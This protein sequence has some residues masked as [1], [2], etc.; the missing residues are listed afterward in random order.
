[1][2]LNDHLS[3]SQNELVRHALSSSSGNRKEKYTAFN[4]GSTPDKQISSN[5]PTCSNARQFKHNQHRPTPVDHRRLTS[6]IDVDQCQLFQGGHRQRVEQD[7]QILECHVKKEQIAKSSAVRLVSKSVPTKID[8]G[9]KAINERND[10]S[11]DQPEKGKRCE[12]KNGCM[13]RINLEENNL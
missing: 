1:M 13:N 11:A 9:E 7:D 8:T 4:D 10:R 3:P 2:L 6:S 5:R 12:E